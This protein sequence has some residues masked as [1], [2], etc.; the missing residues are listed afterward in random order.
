MFFFFQKLVILVNYSRNLFS[1]RYKFITIFININDCIK[2]SDVLPTKNKFQLNLLLS[3]GRNRYI[4][5][6]SFWKLSY[7][8]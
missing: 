7:E 5:I 6:F 3:Q 2:P 8:Q 4:Q 1:T